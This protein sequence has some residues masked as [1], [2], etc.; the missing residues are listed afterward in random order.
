MPILDVEIVEAPGEPGQPGLAQMIADEAGRVLGSAAGRTWIRKRVLPMQDYAENLAVL[1]A[2][3]LPV[4]VEILH[5]QPPTGD[6]LE[7]EIAALTEAIGRAMGRSPA[8]IHIRYA[9]A[10]AGRQAFGG[11]LVR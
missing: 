1:V 3:E 9:P 10:A 5:R 2:D 6:A 7:T 4:F 8:R 11:R